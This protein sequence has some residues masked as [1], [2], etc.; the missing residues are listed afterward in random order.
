MQLFKAVSASDPVT[1]PTEAVFQG[2]FS[3]NP[4]RTVNAPSDS[5]KLATYFSRWVN[6]RGEV[7]PWSTG[8]S[9]VIA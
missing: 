1:D 9:L 4:I 8:A 5:G 3:R 7:G 2:N 6:R